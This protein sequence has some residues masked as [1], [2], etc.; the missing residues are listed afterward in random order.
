MV[1]VVVAQEGYMSLD[2][3]GTP[4]VFTTQAEAD[5][6]AAITAEYQKGVVVEEL[7]AGVIAEVVRMMGEH[8]QVAVIEDKEATLMD[9]REFVGVYG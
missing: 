2:D 4:A 7:S 1:F 5:R 8:N 3:G 9:L 6:A